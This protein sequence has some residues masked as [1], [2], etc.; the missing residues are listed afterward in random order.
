ML[1]QENCSGSSQ[2]R[3]KDKSGPGKTIY[4]TCK[5]FR[6]LHETLH[7]SRIERLPYPIVY[8]IGAAKCQRVI[9]SARPSSV[10]TC[11]LQPKIRSAWL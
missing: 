3:I 10:L 2:A 7:T 1:R 6:V 5:R 9:S 4:I 8:C 11:G